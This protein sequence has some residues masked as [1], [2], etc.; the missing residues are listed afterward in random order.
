MEATGGQKSSKASEEH[1]LRRERN[2]KKTKDILAAVVT[3]VFIPA[4]LSAAL[5]STE[6]RG[7]AGDHRSSEQEER[8]VSAPPNSHGTIGCSSTVEGHHSPLL[9]KSGS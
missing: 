9:W 6:G 7:G 4:V 5:A 3:R 2:F 8:N 1:K